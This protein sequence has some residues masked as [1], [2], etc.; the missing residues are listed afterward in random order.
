LGLVAL[1]G[2][3]PKRSSQRRRR[4][5]TDVPVDVVVVRVCERPH[6]DAVVG[7]VRYD[8]EGRW[9]ALGHEQAVPVKVEVRT[10]RKQ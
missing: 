7:H 1:R 4:N 8:P 5:V 10:E 9:C 6:C 2:P 3:I